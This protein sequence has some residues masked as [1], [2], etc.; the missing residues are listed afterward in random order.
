M[1]LFVFSLGSIK[2]L[3]ANY[4]SVIEVRRIFPSSKSIR[5]LSTSAHAVLPRVQNTLLLI[6]AWLFNA[7][8]PMVGNIK[9]FCSQL[10]NFHVQNF[11]ISMPTSQIHYFAAN[12]KIR[13]SKLGNSHLQ[14]STISLQTPKLQHFVVNFE[15]PIFKPSKLSNCSSKSMFETWK[16]PC[17]KTLFYWLFMVYW[18]YRTILLFSFKTWLNLSNFDLFNLSKFDSICPILEVPSVTFSWWFQFH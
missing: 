15:T 2:R 14:Y 11:I 13:C 9:P 10:R 7:D 6:V 3:I 18:Q 8:D 5:N 16:L 12:F 1:F 17:S 4:K